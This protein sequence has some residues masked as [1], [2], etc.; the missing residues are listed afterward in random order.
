MISQQGNQLVAVHRLHQPL[1]FGLI[2]LREGIVWRDVS[3]LRAFGRYIR[4]SAASFSSDYVAQTLVKYPAIA[5]QLVTLFYAL[6]DPKAQSEKDAETAL[7]K[8]EKALI[9]VYNL[10]EDRII[11]RYVNLISALLRT[12]FFQPAKDDGE[13]GMFIR[14]AGTEPP[15]PAP[16]YTE[17]RNT[18]AEKKS[19]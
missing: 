5:R 16:V 4:Q 8:I 6:F 2:H 18:T 11:R 15:K 17:V 12:N 1:D 7:A 3:L 10:D 13:P 9:D 19:M 14:M